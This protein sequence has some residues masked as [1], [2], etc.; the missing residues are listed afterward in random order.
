LYAS[1]FR[2]DDTLLINTHAHG[3]WAS[4]SPVLR[5]DCATS[6]LFHFYTDAFDRVW[7][8]KDSRPRNEP[9]WDVNA[10]PES[11]P[12]AGQVGWMSDSLGTQVNG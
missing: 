1:E 6:P 2:F 8:D 12:V 11:D 3:L 4:Q 9:G 7:R 10:R 5:I